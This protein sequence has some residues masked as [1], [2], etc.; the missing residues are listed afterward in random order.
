MFYMI[1]RIFLNNNSISFTEH[2]FNLIHFKYN[3]T[4]Y[5]YSDVTKCCICNYRE[6][7]LYD[8]FKKILNINE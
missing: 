8:T 4:S 3:N 1:L 7:S 2:P 5:I 6:Y